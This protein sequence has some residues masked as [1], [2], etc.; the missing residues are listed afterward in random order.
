MILCFEVYHTPCLDTTV[1]RFGLLFRFGLGETNLDVNMGEEA[2]QVLLNA[3]TDLLK[4]GTFYLA[5]VLTS[6]FC[7]LISVVFSV[8]IALFSSVFCFF[9]ILAPGSWGITCCLID[10]CWRFITSLLLPHY[11][12]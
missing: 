9:V 7:C 2:G 12:M 1:T 8:P 11:W 3:P 6:C 5:L 10:F 4:G